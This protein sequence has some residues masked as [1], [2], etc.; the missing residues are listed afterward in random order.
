[1]A[2]WARGETADLAAIVDGTIKEYP[3]SKPGYFI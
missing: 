2:A 1:M 3:G